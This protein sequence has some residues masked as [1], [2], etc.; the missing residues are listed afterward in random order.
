MGPRGDSAA[1]LRLSG[2]EAHLLFFGLLVGL[3]AIDA[4]ITEWL[5]SAGASEFW[6]HKHMSFVGTYLVIVPWYVLRYGIVP[7]S[8]WWPLAW[9]GAL[10][11]GVFVVRRA[12]QIRLPF[13]LVYGVAFALLLSGFA[14]AGWSTI[15]M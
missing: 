3:L 13:R 4:L 5:W 8:P 1:T 2:S 10:L 15:G 11:T 6:R 14:A 12:Q 7:W 9:A